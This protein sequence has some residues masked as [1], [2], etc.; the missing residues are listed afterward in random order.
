MPAPKRAETP[1]AKLDFVNS[2]SGTSVETTSPQP[3]N[4]ALVEQGAVGMGGAVLLNTRALVDEAA[5]G[6]PG[7]RIRFGRY[8]RNGWVGSEFLVAR[9]VLPDGSRSVLHATI[10]GLLE[11]P[12]L[13]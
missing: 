2:G 8:I 1:V 11:A 9:R 12:A 6:A 10:D 5:T 13:P 3:A 4:R 7:T